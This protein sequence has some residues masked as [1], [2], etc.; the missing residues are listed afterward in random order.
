MPGVCSFAPPTRL[1]SSIRRLQG[2]GSVPIDDSELLIAA[3][4]DPDAFAAFYDRHVTS[5]ISYFWRRTHDREIAAELT[6]E[7]FASALASLA[8]YDP[9]KGNGSQWLYGI[10]KNQLRKFWRRNRASDRAR[11][12]MSV[13]MPQLGETGWPEIEAADARLDRDRLLAALERTPRASREAVRLRVVEELTY[14]EIAERLGCE[15]GAARVRVLRGLR[16]L[17]AE[18]DGEDRKGT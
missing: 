14:Q 10:A 6:A 1:W 17:Q 13:R 15:P 12:Q 7:T 4:D 16:R 5:L 3:R 2:G 11:T 8:R 9:A 18:F